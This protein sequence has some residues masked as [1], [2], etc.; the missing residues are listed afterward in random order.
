VHAEPQPS[1]SNTDGAPLLDVPEVELLANLGHTPFSLRHHIEP[2]HPLLTRS[3]LITRAADWPRKLSR[4][5]SGNIQFVMSSMDVDRLEADAVDVMRDI[6]HNSC[7]LVLWELER[8]VRYSAFLDECLDPI[9]RVVGTREGGMTDRGLNIL[10]SSPDAVVP[11][12]F[13]MHHN[14]LLQVDGTKE[15]MI[16]SFG[17]RRVNEQA[18]DRFYDEGN[19]NAR[20]LPDVCT[21]FRLGPGDGVYIPPFAFHWVKGGPETSISISVG[22]RTR[23]T[24]QANLVHEC[25]A[26]LR[27]F[28]LRPSPPGGSERRDRAKVE[29]L[30][31]ARRG[32]RATA[33]MV[34]KVRR[35]M[36]RVTTR[37]S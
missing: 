7:W 5:R 22:F 23:A 13:D 25:N 9:D 30:T 2:R 26:R 28:G 10:A 15:V 29:L 21:S 17:D 35:S 3:A 11:A 12:H 6:D 14:F 27:R 36:R 24:E 16:G 31:W 32:R 1:S 37:A 4:H 33:P 8:S 18:I 20:A 34:T 19:N